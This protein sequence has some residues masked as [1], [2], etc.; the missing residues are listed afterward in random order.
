MVRRFWDDSE[1]GGTEDDDGADE[2]EEGADADAED[3]DDD[4]DD[5]ED[6]DDDDVRI[7]PGVVSFW[8]MWKMDQPMNRRMT[9]SYVNMSIMA[10]WEI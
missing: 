9:S 5:D 3:E 10:A 2:D 8:I 7:P 4:E 1:D 6:E